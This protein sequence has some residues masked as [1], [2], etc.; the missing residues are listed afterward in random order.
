[1]YSQPQKFTNH[2]FSFLCKQLNSGIAGKMAETSGR[3]HDVMD[4][5]FLSYTNSVQNSIVYIESQI[6]NRQTIA[7]DCTC[8]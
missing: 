8:R 3:F 1:M 2:V 5:E 4:M 7:V 6:R